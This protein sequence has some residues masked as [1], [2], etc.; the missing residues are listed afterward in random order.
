GVGWQM[1]VPILAAMIVVVWLSQHRGASAGVIRLAERL[2]FVGA[3]VHHLEDA[4]AS[5][6]E[7]FRLPNLVLAVGIG[8]V[9]WRGG[10]LAFYRVLTALGLP[11]EPILAVQAAFI[12]GT[13]TLVGAASMLP[14]GLAAAEGSLAGLLLL[15]GVTRDP[16]VAAAATLIIR[17]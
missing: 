11:P 5:A 17:F 10:A 12:L 2:P 3:R 15:L 14:G 1:L 13:A 4:I 9:A 7:L 16:S 6:R 8:V